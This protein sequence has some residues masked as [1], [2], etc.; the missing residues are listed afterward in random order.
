[1]GEVERNRDKV[2]WGQCKDLRKTYKRNRE[3]ERDGV[4]KI[5]S[6]P[7]VAGRSS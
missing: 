4:W 3:R 6:L 5:V 2:I 7:P 1:M